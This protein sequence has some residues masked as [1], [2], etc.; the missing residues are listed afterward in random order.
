MIV[1]LEKYGLPDKV[2]LRSDGTAVYATTDIGMARTR[3]EEY[4]NLEKNI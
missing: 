3:F 2:L 1:P 4:P